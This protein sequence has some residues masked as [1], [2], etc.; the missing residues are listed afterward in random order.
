MRA[1]RGTVNCDHSITTT[2]VELLAASSQ[3]TVVFRESLERMSY[4]DFC[5]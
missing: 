5:I 1:S 4:S 3:E 2:S